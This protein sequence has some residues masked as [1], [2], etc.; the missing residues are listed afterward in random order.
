MP[1]PAMPLSAMPRTAII[2]GT[3]DL[4]VQLAGQLENPVYVTFDDSPPPDGVV[5]Q[6]ARIEK[7]GRLFKDLK[8]LGVSEVCFAGAMVRPQINPLLLD[9][10]ALRLAAKLPKGDDALLREVLAVFEESGFAIR[11][12]L[13]I[14]PALALPA[15][16]LWGRKPS[17]G[18]LEDAQKARAVIDALAAQDVGQGAVVAGGL[19]IGIETLQGTNALLKFVGETPKRLRR[20][21]GVFVK[22]PKSGQDL[23]IDAPAIGPKTIQAVT[24]AGLAGLVIAANRTIVLQQAATRAAIEEAGLFLKAE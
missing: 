11:G 9:R 3:G 7:L 21:K 16:T 2:A 14:A 19:V 13:D 23:R 12:A 22:Q 10:H 4:P 15:G 18:D 20:A 1:R 8:A 5:P 6:A 17:A 24:Q